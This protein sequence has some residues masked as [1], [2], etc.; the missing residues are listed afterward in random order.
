MW[1]LM[2]FNSA[3][4]WK[5]TCDFT[6]SVWL[7]IVNN[8]ECKYG[9][10]PKYIWFINS[11]TLGLEFYHIIWKYY[12]NKRT[13]HEWWGPGAIPNTN[14]IGFEGR[15]QLLNIYHL[16]II[17]LF[18]HWLSAGH[19]PMLSACPYSSV[20]DCGTPRARHTS[21]SP[22]RPEFHLLQT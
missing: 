3:I 12:I 9:K 8:D 1:L 22:Q 10:L 18:T 4:G 19:I 17:G 5:S 14:W 21:P 7:V 20:F 2:T 6:K 13:F 15:I 16:Y 11:L